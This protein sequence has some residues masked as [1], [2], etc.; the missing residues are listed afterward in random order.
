MKKLSNNIADFTDFELMYP[1]K[2]IKGA[3]LKAHGKPVVLTITRI[4]PRHELKGKKGDEEYKPCLFFKETEK[5]MVLNV[6]NANSIAA[7]HGRDPRR[8]IGKQVALCSKN[9]K[10]GR[11]RRDCVRIDDNTMERLAGSP[12]MPSRPLDDD[13]R[14]LADAAFA[15]EQESI[16]EHEQEGAV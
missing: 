1:S 3:E 11:E 8:W 12:Q 5:G 10:V 7:H 4:E 14:A 16:E 6:T 15:A 13:E 9:E 2:Y